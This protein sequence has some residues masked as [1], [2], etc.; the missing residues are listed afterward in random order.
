MTAWTPSIV[1]P[2]DNETPR[3]YTSRIAK[4]FKPAIPGFASLIEE[5]EKNFSEIHIVW[6]EGPLPKVN[7]ARPSIPAETSLCSLM[8]MALQENQDGVDRLY[9]D[10]ALFMHPKHSALSRNITFLHEAIYQITRAQGEEDSRTARDA[11]GMAIIQVDPEHASQAEELGLSN[12]KILESL[13]AMGIA[14]P[15]PRNPCDGLFGELKCNM[16][17]DA[18]ISITQKAVSDL[19]AAR[20]FRAQIRHIVIDLGKT[21]VDDLRVDMRWV[22]NAC[23]LEQPNAS[24]DLGICTIFKWPGNAKDYVSDPE[25]QKQL[26]DVGVRIQQFLDKDASQQLPDDIVSKILSSYQSKLFSMGMTESQWNDYAPLLEKTIRTS[27]LTHIGWD[28][29]EWYSPKRAFIESNE[30]KALLYGKW[31]EQPA[32]VSL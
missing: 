31:A 21:Q 25:L 4:R 14:I 22:F 27:V 29:F 8:T 16:D 13:N 23:Q 32:P 11:V 5:G 18:A 7:D 19:P 24:Q 15:D 1:E 20:D 9:I 17:Q 10:R 2:K 30:L 3:A 26:V 6:S 12:T 28:G